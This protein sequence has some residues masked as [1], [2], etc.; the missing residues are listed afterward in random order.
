MNSPHDAEIIVA[1][2]GLAG[3]TVLRHLLSHPSTQEKEILVVDRDHAVRNDKTWCFWSDEDP[4]TEALVAHRW[5]W[6]T[7]ADSKGVYRHKLDKH[8]YKCIRSEDYL[9]ACKTV[10]DSHPNVKRLTSDILEITHDGKKSTLKT[11]AGDLRSTLILQSVLKP[12]PIARQRTPISL[13]QHFL[14]WEIETNHDV[15]DPEV[16]MF[17]DFRTDQKHGFAFVYVLPYSKRHALVE[18]TLFTPSTLAMADYEAAMNAYIRDVLHLSASSWKITRT[19]YGVIPM[20]DTKYPAWYA[21]GVLNM[22]MNGGQSKPST[23]YTFSR[24]QRY[25]LEVAKAVTKRSMQDLN[26]QSANRFL[27]YD[28]L[29]LWLLKEKPEVVPGIFVRLFEKNGADRMFQFLNED[30]HIVQ[31][32]SIM[33][34]TQ[35]R[36][37]FKAIW[38]SIIRG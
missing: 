2:S 24:V 11:S 35:W 15:F 12:N 8:D 6:I 21:H 3:S 17:M 33:A 10:I 9:G 30:T 29:I 16:A 7:I 14:G 36:Y 22:G 25:A 38:R 23:G 37:F 13:L 34:S 31:E 18:Y 20:E 28:R 26:Q 1:G 32:L 4:F 27:L 5:N 19:E